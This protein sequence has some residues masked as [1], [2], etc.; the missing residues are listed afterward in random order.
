MPPR[1]SIRAH[2]LFF[3]C[4]LGL[5]IVALSAC[6]WSD[7]I[8]GDDDDDGNGAGDNT[9]PATDTNVAGLSVAVSGSD[10]DT[11]LANVRSA[12]GDR[13]NIDTITTV[14]HQENADNAGENLRPTTVILFDD[15]D[16]SA[17]LIAAD[18]RVA[19]DLPMRVLVYRDGNGSGS[20]TGNI[21]VAYTNAAYLRARYDLD[22]A[23]QGTLD[24]FDQDLRAIAMDA[25]GDNPSAGAA[26]GVSRR[27][28]I[29][30]VSSDSDFDTTLERL[31][32]AINDRGKLSLI[33][34]IDFQGRAADPGSL[35][36]STLLVF[37][38]PDVGTKFLQSSQTAGVDLP[39]KMLV[40]AGDSGDVTIY[41]NDPRFI[42]DRHGID[43]RGD[44]VESVRDLLETLAGEAAGNS[45]G[46][47]ASDPDPNDDPGDPPATP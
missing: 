22:G 16:R 21:A 5:C 35:N 26:T 2:R 6:E 7:L 37:G 4:L 12:I 24:G 18:P 40:S 9:P 13:A 14:D 39:Q 8:N 28:G 19:V 32:D 43:N 45:S 47:N 44:Q 29:N 20:G 38:N 11:T 17:A 41:Y 15:P 30:R 42:A 34:T 23:E 3:A 33:E 25:T 46:D 31:E 36:P 1:P 27:E 10:F